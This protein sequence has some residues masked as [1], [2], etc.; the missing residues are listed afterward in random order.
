MNGIIEV[1]DFTQIIDSKFGHFI[2][3]KDP[4]RSPAHTPILLTTTAALDRLSS[5][6]TIGIVEKPLSETEEEM[7]ALEQ[8]YKNIKLENNRYLVSWPWKQFPP[9]IPSNLG[10]ALGQLRSLTRQHFLPH[11]EIFEMYSAILE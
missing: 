4:T 11:P 10:L 5:L 1:N 7:N 6:E 8:F 3:G 9:N 2:V